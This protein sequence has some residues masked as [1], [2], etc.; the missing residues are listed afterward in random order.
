[1]IHMGGRLQKQKI[2][3][4]VW[5][6]TSGIWNVPNREN[7]NHQWPTTTTTTT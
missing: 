3:E 6:N 4:K 2:V 1:M 7:P 5:K